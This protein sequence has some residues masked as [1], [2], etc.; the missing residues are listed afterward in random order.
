MILIF[1]KKQSKIRPPCGLV[2]A[3]KACKYTSFLEQELSGVKNYHIAAKKRGDDIIFLRKIVPGGADDS[4]GIEVA[5]LA[6][7]PASVIRRAK[8][9]LEAI[10]AGEHIA[11][12]SARSARSPEEPT[13]QLSL[14]DMGGSRVA[15]R[16][17]DLDLNT[18]TPLEAMNLLYELKRA[19]E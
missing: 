11:P 18:L 17:R 12:G 5:K 4:Y 3:Q 19:I 13:D 2:F 7:V 8:A 9:V 10:E 16:L 6:G 14:T 15:D 1:D